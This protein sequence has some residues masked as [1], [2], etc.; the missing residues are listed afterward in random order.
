MSASSDLLEF[1]LSD[2]ETEHDERSNS[3]AADANGTKNSP[4]G[5]DAHDENIIKKTEKSRTA[6][7]PFT[8]DILTGEDGIKRIYAG[9][10]QCQFRGRGF[11]G[12]D[13]KRLMNMYKEWS[14]QLYPG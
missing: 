12:Q 4:K 2:S 3:G 9:F 7:A 8:E 1:E 13:V 10:P 6:R 11:E 14:K 5:D